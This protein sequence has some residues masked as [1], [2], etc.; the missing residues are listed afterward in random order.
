MKNKLLLFVAVLLA[1]S[2]AGCANKSEE[3]LTFEDSCW[4]QVKNLKKK[5][6]EDGNVSVSLTAPDYTAVI[7]YLVE[8]GVS[9]DVTLE[10]ISDAIDANPK[11]VKNYSFVVESSDEEMIRDALIEQI[12]IDLLVIAMEDCVG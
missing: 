8:N 10:M 7:Q 2:L 3:P 11:A 4:E 12:A 9:K 1:I 6:L 5:K